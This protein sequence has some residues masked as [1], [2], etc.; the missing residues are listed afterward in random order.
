ML[1]QAMTIMLLF[2]APQEEKPAV[3]PGHAPHVKHVYY[4]IFILRAPSYKIRCWFTSRPSF[5]SHEVT[6]FTT[7]CCSEPTHAPRVIN[8]LSQTS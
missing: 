2:C 8:M 6:T 1:L 3:A 7:R 5:Q 4:R